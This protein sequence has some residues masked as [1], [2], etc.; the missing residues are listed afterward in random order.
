MTI[1]CGRRYCDA[2][3]GACHLGEHPQTACPE[4]RKAAAAAG[5]T[6]PNDPASTDGLQLPW[7]GYALGTIDAHF[8]TGRSSSRLVGIVGPQGAGKTTLLA[9]WYAILSIG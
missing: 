3:K 1:T 5:I 7:S 8:V 2:P 6:S 4:W 9:A